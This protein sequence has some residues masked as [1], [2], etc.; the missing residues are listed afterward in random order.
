MVDHDF[1]T[2]DVCVVVKTEWV[3]DR[4]VRHYTREDVAKN[5]DAT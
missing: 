3:T 5:E 1:G 4:Y 2:T